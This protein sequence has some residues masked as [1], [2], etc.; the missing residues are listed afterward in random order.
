MG[1]PV[2]ALLFFGTFVGDSVGEFVG[3]FERDYAG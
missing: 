1:I 3:F 2:V